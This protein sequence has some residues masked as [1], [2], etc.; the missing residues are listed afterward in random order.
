MEIQVVSRIDTC[1]GLLH[2]TEYLRLFP[3]GTLA[4]SLLEYCQSNIE[5]EAVQFAGS[6]IIDFTPS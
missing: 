1:S 4:I 6:A 3:A 2:E 5:D